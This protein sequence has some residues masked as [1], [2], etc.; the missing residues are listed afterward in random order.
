MGL[1]VEIRTRSP[2]RC[3]RCSSPALLRVE[4]PDPDWPGG[5]ARRV[6]VLCPRCNDGDPY[7]DG[8]LAFFAL[9]RTLALNNS[10]E[11]GALVD[12]WIAAPPCQHRRSI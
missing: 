10:D 7:T 6:L 5:A 1:P 4:V 2:G 11:F 12:Q 9:H 8:L 3:H